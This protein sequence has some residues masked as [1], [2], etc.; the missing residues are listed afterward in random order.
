[1]RF[2]RLYAVR[3]LTKLRIRLIANIDLLGTC[4]R[5]FERFDL[6]LEM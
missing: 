5:A 6:I 4:E 1:M 3:K 2:L